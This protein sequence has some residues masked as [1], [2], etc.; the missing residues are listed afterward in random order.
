[1]MAVDLH[2]A[3]IQGFF[4]GPV[5]HLFALPLLAAYVQRRVDHGTSPSSPR[6]PVGSVSPSGGRR[7]LGG[8][9]LAFIH[10]TRDPDRPNQVV[11]QPCRR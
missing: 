7:R 6:T 5:D 11:G 9:P 4:D 1:M 3:Q 8:A 2:T 10:K